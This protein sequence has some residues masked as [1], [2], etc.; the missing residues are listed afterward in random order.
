MHIESLSLQNF[1]GHELALFKSILHIL[2]QGDLKKSKDLFDSL[3]PKTI[4][5][6]K[7]FRQSFRQLSK[8]EKLTLFKEEM[9]TEVQ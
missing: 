8:A 6:F 1:A 9:V 3:D 4:R 5:R 2:A 7:E